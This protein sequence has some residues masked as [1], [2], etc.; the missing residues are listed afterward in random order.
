MRRETIV[1]KALHYEDVSL[2]EMLRPEDQFRG[3]PAARRHHREPARRTEKSNPNTSHGSCII[4]QKI[5]FHEI[6]DDSL[7]K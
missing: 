1:E 4:L 3:Q 5:V 2:V 7:K 6:F